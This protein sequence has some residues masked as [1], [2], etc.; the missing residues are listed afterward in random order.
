MANLTSIRLLVVVAFGLVFGC[1][2][3]GRPDPDRDA[4]FATVTNGSIQRGHTCPE[5]RDAEISSRNGELPM[6]VTSAVQRNIEDAELGDVQRC[7]AE[8]K[9]YNQCFLDLPCEA[10]SSGTTPAWLLGAE[11]APC[12]CGVDTEKVP[13]GPFAT[14]GVL[15]DTLAACAGLLPILS[16]LPRPIVSCP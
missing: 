11:A 13:P 7:L 16:P 3:Q 9:S 12:G 10:F 14:R 1:A 15:P 8:V 6:S 5:V 2:G 4:L